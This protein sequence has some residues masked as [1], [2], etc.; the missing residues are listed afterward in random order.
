MKSDQSAYLWDT[1]D[2][3]IDNSYG[4][5]IVVFLAFYAIYC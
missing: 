5:C 4:V 3:Q 2:S 1:C